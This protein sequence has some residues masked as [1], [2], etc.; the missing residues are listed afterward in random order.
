MR[1]YLY[2]VLTVMIVM[3]SGCGSQKNSTSDTINDSIQS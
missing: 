2:I 3:V 1:K